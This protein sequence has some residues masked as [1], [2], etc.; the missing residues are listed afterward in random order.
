MKEY[1]VVFIDDVTDERRYKTVRARDKDAVWDK[2]EKYHIIDI[3][4]HSIQEDTDGELKE[5]ITAL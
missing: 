3:S 5:Y 1:D 2:F 4:E